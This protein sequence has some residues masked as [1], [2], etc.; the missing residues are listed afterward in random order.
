M[1][2]TEFQEKK[3]ENVTSDSPVS[4]DSPTLPLP[5][6]QQPSSENNELKIKH[7]SKEPQ[8]KSEETKASSKRRKE[9]NNPFGFVVPRARSYVHWEDPTY[10]GAVLGLGLLLVIFTSQVSLFNTFCALAVIVLS[11]NWIY[12]LG[13]KQ[14]QVLL[15]KENVSPYEHWFE[16]KPWYIERSTVEKYLDTAVE[17]INF[18][19]QESQKIVLVDDPMRT[20]K[21]IFLFYLAWTVGGWFSL[22][23]I[24]AIALIFG[25]TIPPA[26]QRHNVLV[27]EKLGKA[28]EIFNA[29]W[30]RATGTLKHHTK[31]AV[32]KGRSFAAEKGWVSKDVS[33]EE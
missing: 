33:K 20:L 24:T 13:R 9:V 2:E 8:E 18:I 4:A 26:Y 28:R 6:P 16:E 19:L 21:Y 7:T 12:V 29:N 14:F 5:P 23:T 1:S 32:E 3:V 31:G 15:N 17:G 25:F 27:D 10:S 30:E 22:H 11:A